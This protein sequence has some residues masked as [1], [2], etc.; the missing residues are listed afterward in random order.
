MKTPARLR[1]AIAV[2]V[3]SAGAATNFMETQTHSQS[4]P[5][6][7]V[8]AGRLIDGVS[9]EVR[10][11]VSII[12]EGDRISEVSEG[13][14]NVPGAEVI[15]LSDSTVM[16]GFIDCHTHLTFQLGRGQKLSDFVLRRDAASAIASTAYARRT[17]L[18]GFTT[19]RDVGGA[20]F[21]DIELRDAINAGVVEGPRMFVAGPLLTITGGHADFTAGMREGLLP[22][23]DYRDGVID[24]PED[25]V[26]AV[27]YL[28]KH[29]VDHIKMVATGGVISIADSGSGQQLTAAEMKAIVEAA[30]ELGRKVACHAHGA[31]GIKDAVRAGTDSV[32][33]GS[34]LDDEAIALMKE[35]GTY[36]VPTLTV[37][38]FA[39]KKAKE[40]G[41]FPPPIQAKVL[42][43]SPL[44]PK[45][46]AK[47]YKA[48]VKIAL[49][50]DA[51]VYPH[52]QNAEEFQYLV[53][54]GLSPMEAI[55]A[56]TG[57][58]ADLLG[59]A[60]D[61]GSVRPGRYADLVAVRQDPLKDVKILQDVGFVMKAG[62][63]YKR[64]GQ[65]VPQK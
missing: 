6:K 36:L 60:A 52:G 32:E 9:N 42:E 62:K 1:A 63:V 19:V 39:E 59:R 64:D 8:Y 45:A 12:I 22:E 56:G 21:L 41:Y 28:A 16:P 38:K 46:T 57:R 2:V 17:L 55:Q 33:H 23:P 65:P 27:H 26:R 24:T 29:G 61:L 4:P 51:G 5:V 54:A 37:A 48:G 49:G 40:P 7:V 58:A 20:H 44:P 50:T 15:D 25:A 31:S 35:H 43:V 14:A 13:R 34:Y 11:N 3:L 47:A 30:H 53:E 18:A 10:S